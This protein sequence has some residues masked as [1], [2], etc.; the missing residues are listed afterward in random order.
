MELKNIQ[1]KHTH[2]TMV[3]H[4]EVRIWSSKTYSRNTHTAPWSY[5]QRSEYGAQKHTAETHTQHHGHTY[6][7]QNMELKNIQPK[8]THSTMVIHTEV[9]IWSLKHTAETHTQHHGHTYRGQNMELKTYSQ[10][11][12][13]AP[14]SY[15]QRSEYGA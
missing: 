11:T 12:H 1:P 13:T 10:N 5:I 15:I 6:R 4:T 2:S 8:H 7:G 9:R 3:I 14:W